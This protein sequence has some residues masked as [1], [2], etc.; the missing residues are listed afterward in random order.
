EPL[1]AA[2]GADLEDVTVKSAGRRT[3][4][5]IF[6]DADGGIGLDEI[7]DISTAI[8]TKLDQ[9]DLFGAAPYTLEVS[10]PGADRPLTAPKHWRRAAGRLVRA[11]LRSGVEIIGRVAESDDSAVTLDVG[12]DQ[13]RLAY[14]EIAKARVEVEFNR[15]GGDND[16]ET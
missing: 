4:L 14:E 3:L 7:A 15:P 8:S 10:S 11:H 5:Q 12:G 16:E 1:V 9:I 6:V 2:A 13:Q